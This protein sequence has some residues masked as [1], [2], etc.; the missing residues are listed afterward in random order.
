MA[1]SPAAPVVGAAGSGRVSVPR[2]S[3]NRRKL[4]GTIGYHAVAGGISLL[5][6]APLA[7]VAVTSFRT[8]DDVAAN[9]IVSWPDRLWLG[10][11]AGAWTDGGMRGAL[12]DSFIITIPA[13]LLSMILSAV[14]A[15]GLSRYR[16]PFRRTILLIMLSGNLLPPQTL[17]VP[18]N[19]IS[20]A[21]GVFDT[22]YAVIAIH[23]SFGLGFYT[24]L[25]YGFMR[26]L[27]AEIQQAAVID[28]ASTLQIFW[29]IILPLSRPALAA[30]TALAFTFIFNDLLWSITLLRSQDL[31]P[32]TPTLLGLQGS[33]ISDYTLLAAGTVIA[34]VP[35]LAVFLMFQRYFVDGITVGAVK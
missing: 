34:A 4:A 27:P 28:G 30:T 31:M 13:V 19:K 23:I 20:E 1:A 12:V 2:E 8:F 9:G 29:R 10:S 22:Y 35:T 3:R 32:V 26:A 5:W 17:I 21:L 7:I 11:Y 33:Y 25:L 6:F 16:M 18:L 15:F 14:A 24:F